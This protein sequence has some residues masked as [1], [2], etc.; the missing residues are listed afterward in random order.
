[1]RSDACGT[2]TRTCSSTERIH[3][4]RGGRRG[5]PGCRSP[6]ATTPNRRLAMSTILALDLGKY[7]SVACLYDRA[8]AAARFH[9]LDT[10]REQL[11]QLFE[12]HRPAV[13]V[14]EACA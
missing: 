8:T 9:A 1:M 11:R 2:S 3:A 12:R 5:Y 7:K 10:N 4:S 14:F 6:G 13:V